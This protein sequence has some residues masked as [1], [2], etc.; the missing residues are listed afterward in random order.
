M[1]SSCGLIKNPTIDSNF[2]KTYK[3]RFGKFSQNPDRFRQLANIIDP[4]PLKIPDGAT[5]YFCTPIVRIEK[6][7]VTHT[8]DL[9]FCKTS[10]VYWS[11]DF[12]PLP[13]LVSIF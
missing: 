10:N 1:T 11:W 4:G 2:G 3:P 12:E 8:V 5:F 7:K 9:N 13:L 6:R